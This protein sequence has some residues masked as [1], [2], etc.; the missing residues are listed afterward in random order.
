[1]EKRT[2]TKPVRQGFLTEPTELSL[3]KRNEIRWGLPITVS[4]R[5]KVPELVPGS[6]PDITDTTG[7]MSELLVSKNPRYIGLKY[8][9]DR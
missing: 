6:S 2:H 4:N 5:V 7:V 9:G 8:P 1:M 3:R